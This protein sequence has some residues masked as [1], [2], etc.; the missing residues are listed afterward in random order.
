[1]KSGNNILKK[2]EEVVA[3][4]WAYKAKCSNPS[5]NALVPL[6]R[7]LSLCSKKDK[8]VSLKPLV[9]GNQFNLSV[10][11]GDSNVE[12]FIKSKNLV[13]PCCGNI[14]SKNDLRAQFINKETKQELIAVITDGQNGKDYRLPTNEE[15]E[16]VKRITERKMIYMRK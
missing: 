12:P 1:M 8:I 6:L 11:H 15:I 2:G 13:C 14:T 9:E 7:K 4:Y 3:Y 16:V 5:C 10:V